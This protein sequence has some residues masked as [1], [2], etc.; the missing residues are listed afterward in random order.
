MLPPRRAGHS[1]RIV[2]RFQA[3]FGI[4][5][6]NLSS[7]QGLHYLVDSEN[8]KRSLIVD[9]FVFCELL[10]QISVLDPKILTGPVQ[11]RYHF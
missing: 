3:I 10:M 1:I 5:A 11:D 4:T 2:L 9:E 8:F 7:I 6:Y